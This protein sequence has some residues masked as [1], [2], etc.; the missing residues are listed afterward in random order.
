MQK[1][2]AEE[3][4]SVV[5]HAAHVKALRRSLEALDSFFLQPL[6]RIQVA[7]LAQRCGS[8]DVLG[9]LN[10][11]YQLLLIEAIQQFLEHARPLRVDLVKEFFGSICTCARPQ[12]KVWMRIEGTSI[13]LSLFS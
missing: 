7:Q 8:V 2:A 5:V 11:G 13:T 1:P 6:R 12:S 10:R 3:G 9:I 4:I